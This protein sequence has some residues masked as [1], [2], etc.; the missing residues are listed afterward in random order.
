MKTSSSVPTLYRIVELCRGR[1]GR[2]E[3]VAS[4]WFAD[5]N[6]VRAIGGWVARNTMAHRMW[7]ASSIQPHFEEIPL[8]AP[9][10]SAGM[11]PLTSSEDPAVQC[12]DA[13]AVATSPPPELSGQNLADELF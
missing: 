7:I 2:L 6:R 12:L 3:K 9:P 4:A 11:E 10:H 8:S 13:A 1:G 5:V